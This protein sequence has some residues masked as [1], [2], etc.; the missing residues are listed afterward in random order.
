MRFLVLFLVLA[1]TAAVGCSERSMPVGPSEP[2]GKVSSGGLFDLFK[3]GGS[4]IVGVDS[5][6]VE[7]PADSTAAAGADSTV[8][9]VTDTTEAE[10]DTPVP[11]VF[12][13]PP[14]ARA[15]LDSLGIEYTE[16]AFLDSARSGNL[17]VVRLFV[18]GGM[19]VKATDSYGE[20][21]LVQAARGGHLAVVRYLVGQGADVNATYDYSYD[22]ETVLHYAAVGG[23]LAVVRYLVGQGASVTVTDN[24]G[25]TPRDV[26]LA[27]GKTAVADYLESVG[28]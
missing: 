19:S 1:V 8:T 22:G 23:H 10:E 9:A 26:A 27:K 3:E 24:G 12:R 20:T 25:R 14:A 16:E 2:S 21:A 15:A 4:A 18:Q 28:G 11:V 13:S 17:A 7:T 6:A 5:T